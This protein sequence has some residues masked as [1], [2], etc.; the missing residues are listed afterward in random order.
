MERCKVLRV[1][2]ENDKVSSVDTDQGNIA[3]KF[4]VNCAGQVGELCNQ[5]QSGYVGELRRVRMAIRMSLR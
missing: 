2:T 1:R 5:A 4:F 3:C